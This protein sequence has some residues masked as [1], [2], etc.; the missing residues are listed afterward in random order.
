MEVQ[1]KTEMDKS[2]KYRISLG[3]KKPDRLKIYEPCIAFVITTCFYAL[4]GL[5]AGMYPFGEES[6]QFGDLAGQFV[7][8]AAVSRD[9]AIGGSQLSD[10]GFTWSVGMGVPNYG[11]FA[12]YISNPL[13]LILVLFPAHHIQFGL[14]VV[15]LCLIGL[16]AVAM[17]VLLRELVP[18]GHTLFLLALSVSYGLSSW[19]V[20]D[21]DYVPMWL[22]GVIGLPLLVLC[23]IWA[24]KRKLF[25]LSVLLIA[26]VWFS[27]YYTAYM[28]SIGAAVIVGLILKSNGLETR[29]V[30]LSL[31]EFLKRGILG[32]GLTAFILIPA[33]IE[34]TNSP[35]DL[36]NRIPRDF[37]LRTML[38]HIFPGIESIS[39][40]PSLY[41]GSVAL[42]LAILFLLEPGHSIKKRLLWLGGLSLT[43]VSMSLQPFLYLWHLAD[44]PNGSSWRSAFVIV[45]IIVIMAWFGVQEFAS[46]NLA[47]FFSAAG[48]LALLAGLT[49]WSV[50]VGDA[51][52]FTRLGLLSSAVIGILLFFVWKFRMRP[53]QGKVALGLLLFTLG[54]ELVGNT[55]FTETNFSKRVAAFPVRSP[56]HQLS[57]EIEKVDWPRYRADIQEYSDIRVSNGGATYSAPTLNYYSSTIP[58]K[59]SDLLREGLQL[60]AGNRSRIVISALSD[61]VGHAIA[62]VRYVYS[63]D[64]EKWTPAFP[65]VRTLASPPASQEHLRPVFLARNEVIGASVYSPPTSVDM[66]NDGGGEIA[67][68]IGCPLGNSASFDASDMQIT[69]FHEDTEY[70]LID[71]IWSPWDQV[72]SGSTSLSL[73]QENLAPE[74]VR[75]RL[76]CVDRDLLNSEIEETEIP[77]VTAKP[78][79]ISASFRQAQNSVL[80]ATTAFSHWRCE[81]PDGEAATGSLHGLLTV[82]LDGASSVNCTYE[83]PGKSLGVGMTAISILGILAVLVFSRLRVRSRAVSPVVEYEGGDGEGEGYGQDSHE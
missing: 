54:L 59:T 78:G 8:F 23:G 47:R 11:N 80:I 24:S 21:A 3:S 26:L 19:I 18:Q 27:N 1:T 36:D 38:A 77:T 43:I 70:V 68:N 72:D 39:L 67:V 64:D 15:I 83:N 81:S 73:I 22:S 31:L 46:L 37:P 76:A 33:Y 65:T 13:W 30:F 71:E 75:E 44:V 9:M 49:M 52:S 57:F 69:L 5:L 35:A 66:V 74:K 28:A 14:W 40:A 50:Y 7:P 42:I 61:P 56:E 53:W 82:D 29:S 45:A 32:V 16:S 34:V 48:I 60:G 58:A 79:E 62:S 4:A 41:V 2:S 6:Q 51:A 10:I 12:S 25:L 55:V 63:P 17:A 20:Q